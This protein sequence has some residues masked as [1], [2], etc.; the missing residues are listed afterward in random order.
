[1]KYLSRVEPETRFK[2][3]LFVEVWDGENGRVYFEKGNRRN[4]NKMKKRS[5]DVVGTYAV[6]TVYPSS[7]DSDIQITKRMATSVAVGY[8]TGLHVKR[9][10]LRE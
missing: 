1:M 4:A 10:N 3:H 9:L 6:V 7:F 2:D 8:V 5:M